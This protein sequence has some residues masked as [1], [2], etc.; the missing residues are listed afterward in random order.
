MYLIVLFY[1]SEH[2]NRLG[3]DGT[4]IYHDLKTLSGA[5]RRASHHI[6]SWARTYGVFRAPENGLYRE[7]SWK[8]LVDGAHV[9]Y[10]RRSR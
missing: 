4:R 7:Q 3:S 10:L 8:L 1:D 6:P 9:D 2:R 5:E